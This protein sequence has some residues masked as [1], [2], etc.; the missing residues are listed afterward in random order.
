MKITKYGHSCLFIEEGEAKILIDPGIFCFKDTDWKP[1]D[2]PRCDVLL[3]THEH[4]DHTHPEAIKVIVE[5]SKP[6]ILTNASVQKMLQ[7]HGIESEVLGRR[8][9]RIVHGVAIRAVDCKHEFIADHVPTPENIG[10]LIAGRLFH[11]GDCVNPSES[12]QCE[13]LAAPVVAPWMPVRDGIEFIKKIKPKYVIPIHDG[14]VKHHDI[15]WYRIFKGGLEGTGI[16][17]QEMAIDK[18]KEF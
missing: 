1:E 10:F 7:D 13:I 18:T 3:L 2:L 5:K 14:I 4:A 12:V 8:E 17:F 15:L 9:E 11:P 6:M 16:E